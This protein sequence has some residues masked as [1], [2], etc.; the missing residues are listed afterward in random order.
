MRL[1]RR[2]TVIGLGTL[3]VG[4]GVISGSGAFDS[5]EANRSFEVSV[6]GDEGALLGLEATNDTIT[7]T[8]SGGAG[9]NDVIYFELTDGDG[10]QAAI[11][12]DAV[13]DF[14]D[15]MRVTNN[16]S[17]TVTLS[18]ELDSG[19]SGVSFLLNANPDEPDSE[20]DLTSEG[21]TLT[22]GESILVDLRIDTTTDGGYV[23]PPSS[24]P[25]QITIQAIAQ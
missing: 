8:E 23:E 14:F 25:Y 4:A 21:H 2:N 1:S 19:L 18:I 11:N 16:G 9:G 13:T 17:Q 3:A 7:G 20:K 5:V 15:V 12:E 10:G 22:T 24:D 6:S